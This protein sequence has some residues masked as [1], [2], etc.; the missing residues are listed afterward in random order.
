MRRDYGVTKLFEEDRKKKNVDYV[1][2]DDERGTVTCN[3][4]VKY[5]DNIKKIIAY[6]NFKRFGKNDDEYNWSLL[7]VVNRIKIREDKNREAKN[8]IR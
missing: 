3:G 1:K 6:I 2:V 7:H 5:Y 8:E 4:K